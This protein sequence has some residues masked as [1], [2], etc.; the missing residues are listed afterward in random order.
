MA[1]RK[2]GGDCPRFRKRRE[3]WI[4]WK[5]SH[6]SRRA[7][8]KTPVS[9]AT[10]PAYYQVARDGQDSSRTR[11]QDGWKTTEQSLTEHSVKNPDVRL[12]CI[13]QAMA[14]VVR[15]VRCNRHAC[16]TENRCRSAL[17]YIPH[18][19]LPQGAGLA[20]SLN[21]NVKILLTFVTANHVQ[22]DSTYR[23]RK[24]FNRS[25]MQQRL[26]KYNKTNLRTQAKKV[27][28]HPATN[29]LHPQASS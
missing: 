18:F 29:S 4:V 10:C 12:L 9:G 2:D 13:L 16:G 20:S 7:I 22:S 3:A 27:R 17:L 6:W 23:F 28:L 5:E 24:T 14:W 21:M 26:K 19:G 25:R 1:Q 8:I 15:V 11:A